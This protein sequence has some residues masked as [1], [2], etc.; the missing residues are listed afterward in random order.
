MINYMV[1]TNNKKH[2]TVIML[3]FSFEVLKIVYV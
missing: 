3:R 1:N 2:G